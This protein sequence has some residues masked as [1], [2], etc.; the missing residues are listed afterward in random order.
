MK[1]ICT[2]CRFWHERLAPPGFEEYRVG[3][4]RRV[5]PQRDADGNLIWPLLTTNS[6]VCSLWEPDPSRN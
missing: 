1:P 5:E 6:M 3:Q 4:C 2:D